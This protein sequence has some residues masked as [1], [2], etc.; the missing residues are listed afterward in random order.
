MTP[1]NGAGC[2]SGTIAEPDPLSIDGNGGALFS[3]AGSIT[4]CRPLGPQAG[5]AL[6]CGC[7]CPEA[8]FPATA[9]APRATG[10]GA[11]ALAWGL[12]GVPAFF[13]TM[14]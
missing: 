9:T 12:T 3:S 10:A 14:A 13:K 11:A 4:G 8:V 7:R 6:P 5:P 1:D 2:K